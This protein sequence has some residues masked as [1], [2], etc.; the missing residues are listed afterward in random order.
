MTQW[1]FTVIQISFLTEIILLRKITWWGPRGKTPLKEE[2]STSS[3]CNYASQL[4]SAAG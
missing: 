2:A 3:L 4:C 1:D